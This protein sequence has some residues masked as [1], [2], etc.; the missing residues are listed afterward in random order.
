MQGYLF[1]CFL[2]FFLWLY[3]CIVCMNVCMYLC[4]YACMHICMYVCISAP[5]L[6]NPPTHPNTSVPSFDHLLWMHTNPCVYASIIWPKRPIPNTYLAR[7]YIDQQAIFMHVC[8]YVCIYECMYV[9]M[10]VCMY[11]S[12]CVCIFI[13]IH[14]YICVCKTNLTRWL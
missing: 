2:F 9:S 1:L 14:M 10:S 11:I 12:M 5:P 13:Y 4:I 8:M 7:P 3:L 6:P